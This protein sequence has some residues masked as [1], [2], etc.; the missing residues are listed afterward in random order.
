MDRVRLKGIVL[1]GHVG[2][3]E[4]ER[5]TGQKLEIDVELSAD[6]EVAAAADA[7]ADTLDYEKIYRS[8]EA[9]VAAARCRLLETLAR[10]LC[11]TLLDGFEVTEVTVR[12]RKPN[13]PFAGTLSAA[14]VEF[15]RRR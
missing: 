1:F 10:T 15:T 12:V 9:T 3:H 11:R 4:A 7:L 6:L 5:D 14:E 2:V 8:V 13:V